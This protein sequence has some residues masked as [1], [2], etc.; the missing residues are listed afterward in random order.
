M[1]APALGD[2]WHATIVTVGS[3]AA[4][5]L[6]AARAVGIV[7]SLL[8]A[9]TQLQDNAISF[10][11]KLIAVATV[12]VVAGPWALERL[13]SHAAQTFEI[14]ARLGQGAGP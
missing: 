13:V 11:P 2:L 7:T 14:V 12:L 3:V 6:A 1:N 10:V 5:F 4:P 8:Q 9:A